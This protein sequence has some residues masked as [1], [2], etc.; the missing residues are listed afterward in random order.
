MWP[1]RHVNNEKG[2]GKVAKPSLCLV[3]KANANPDRN[4]TY[5]PRRVSGLKGCGNGSVAG[6]NAVLI[7]VVGDGEWIDLLPLSSTS[8]NF[9]GGVS[10]CWCFQEGMKGWGLQTEVGS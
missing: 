4:L 6:M 7:A 8:F 10:V 2:V 3:C 5:I 1:V 9:W